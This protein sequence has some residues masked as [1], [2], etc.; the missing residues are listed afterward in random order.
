MTSNEH[1]LADWLDQPSTEPDAL[2]PEVLEVVYALRPDLAPAPRVTAD[3]ILASV[4]EGPLAAPEGPAPSSL[5][6][7]DEL[8]TVAAPEPANRSLASWG[9]W[10]GIGLVIAAAATF[11]LVSI[12]ALQGAAPDSTPAAEPAPAVALPA[13]PPAAAVEQAPQRAAEAPRQ[14][15]APAASPAHQA[16]ARPKAAPRPPSPPPAVRESA[17]LASDDAFDMA[18]GAPVRNRALIPE[19]ADMGDD[20]VADLEAE[21]LD[22]SLEQAAAPVAQQ[23]AAP[24]APDAIEAE[25][26]RRLDDLRA[27]AMSAIGAVPSWQQ[28]LS[29]AEV[30]RLSA[31]F[32]AAAAA[33]D[34]RVAGDRAV[35][36]IQPPA[37]VAHHAA[38]L[39]VDY[40]LSAGDAAGAA[41]AAMRGLQYKTPT[42]SWAHLAVRYAD[43]LRGSNPT[44]A[45]RWYEAAAE[46][47]R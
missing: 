34:L 29:A 30:Q 23:A 26:A 28:G 32:D 46:A 4:S 3:D 44:E 41:S 12:P 18:N 6:A 9:S 20:A 40:Y 37:P 14:Q 21:P 15:A 45:A 27:A 7:P 35:A 5:P 8:A 2:D 47:A 10:G 42:A 19:L 31:Q 33:S 17:P 24:P 13:P 43:L 11:A 25:S 39:A 16:A 22:P 36:A 1:A 38:E